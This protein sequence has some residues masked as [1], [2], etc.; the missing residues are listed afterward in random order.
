MG[1]ASSLRSRGSIPGFG[2]L[3]FGNGADGTGA[4]VLAIA[5][6]G[7]V[8]CTS[9]GVAFYWDQA[10]GRCS[11][12][13]LLSQFGYEDALTGWTFAEAN[14]ITPNGKVIIGCGVTPASASNVQA[15][16]I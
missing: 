5:L 9:S 3:R 11:L 15:W 7:G 4:A 12:R 13:D 14:A 6:G 8:L 16:R 10:G 1:T 2:G